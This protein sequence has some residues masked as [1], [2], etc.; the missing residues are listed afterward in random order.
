MENKVSYTVAGTFV[1]VLL[2]F[3]I[4]AIIWLSAGFNN[5]DYVYYTVYMKESISGLSKDGPVEFNGV[6]VGTVEAMKINRENPQLVQL[7]L[8]VEED[9]PVT[10]GTKAKLGLKALTGVAYLLLEDKGTD[11]RLLKSEGKPY[12]VIPTTPSILVRLET[13]LTQMNDSFQQV[14]KSIRALLNKENLRSVKQLLQ[15]GSGSFKIL[16]TE[17]IPATNEAISNLGIITRDLTSVSS[18]MKENPA[19]IIR[20]KDSSRKLGPGEQ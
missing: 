18:D 19:V 14:S 15:S 13:T 20:G 5:K 4:V 7:T 2:S 10:M 3:I 8:K 17:T 9:T 6:N 11:M 12:P 1:L 16:E